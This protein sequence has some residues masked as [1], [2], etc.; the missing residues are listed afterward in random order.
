MNEERVFNIFIYFEDDCAVEYGLRH[1]KRGGSDEEKMAWLQSSVEQ[2]FSSARRFKLRRSFSGREWFAQQRLGVDLGLFEDGFV[3]SNAPRAPI[4]CITAI[5]DGLPRVDRKTDLLPF[6]GDKVGKELPGDMQDWLIKYTEGK[7]FR[8]D[9]LMNDDYFV[10]IKLLFNERKIASASK[11]LMSSID[12]MAFV[13][14]G[15]KSGNFAKWLDTYVDL[16]KVGVSSSELWEFRNS[17]VHMTNLSSRAVIAGKVTPIMP[18]LGSDELAKFAK[19]TKVKPFNFYSLITA[20]A[21]GIKNWSESYNQ[22]PDK[23]L[24]F[25]ER[26]DTMISDSRTAYISDEHK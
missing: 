17:V 8:F 3:V 4:V 22:T 7:T 5:V 21:H 26:Y 20:V 13:E 2:D 18:Y 12:T 24:T 19:S 9:K 15:D 14:Y 10:A 25:I 6:W 23:F 16:T 11:L 1:H